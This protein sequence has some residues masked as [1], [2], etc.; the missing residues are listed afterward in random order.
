ILLPQVYY[1][2]FKIFITAAH[3]SRFYVSLVEFT[4]FSFVLLILILDL[5]KL[6][7]AS[8]NLKI[9]NWERISL[10]IFSFVNLIL[11]TLTGT[12]SSIPRYALFSVSFFIF[13][14]EIKNNI[15]KFSIAIIFLILHIL[16]LGYF[17]QGYFI[18]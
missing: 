13:L 8:K 4:V 7:C 9:K 2:Y 14:A 6:A 16:L 1:R 17:T 18:S 5:I 11:P 3:D 15:V 12:F 10:S